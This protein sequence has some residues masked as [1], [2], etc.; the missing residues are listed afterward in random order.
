MAT[1]A[2]AATMKG[3]PLALHLFSELGKILTTTKNKINHRLNLN[4]YII[5][6]E[7]KSRED[8]PSQRSSIQKDIRLVRL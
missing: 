8:G 2:S 5:S 1:M 6:S 4:L 7:T 3:S